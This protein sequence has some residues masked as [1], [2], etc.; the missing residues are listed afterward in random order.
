M[1]FAWISEQTTIIS[2]YS[3]NLSVFIT[4]AESVY[5]VIQTG[6]SNQTDTV[7]FLKG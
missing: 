1:Y 6:F 3:F 4:A 7:S 2:P 5:Y